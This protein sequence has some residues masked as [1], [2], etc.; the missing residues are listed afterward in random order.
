VERGQVVGDVDAMVSAPVHSP[1][2]GTVKAIAPRLLASGLRAAVVSI[3]PDPEQDWESW[4]A[5]PE[6]DDPRVMVRAAGIV[7][8]GGAAFPTTVKLTP[9]HDMPIDTLIL[10]G[11]ECEPYLT[12][13]HRVMLEY[14]EKV[15]AGA[16]IMAEVVGAERVV[17][18]IEDNK[19]DAAEA[20]RGFA[21]TD[22]EIL[23]LPTN[24]PQ[25]AEKQ[26]ILAVLGKEV[27]HEK[28]PAATGAL[29]QNRNRRTTSL[30]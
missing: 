8:M 24:Y 14:P 5:L 3:A 28:L 19:T 9:P 16:R 10:N 1:V 26:L 13:D 11:C 21:G 17:V 30:R 25:G 20:L 29:V 4:V 27:P 18:G 12:C 6:S 15:I 7:G 23:V 22:V 2:S